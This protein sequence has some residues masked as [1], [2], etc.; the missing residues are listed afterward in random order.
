MKNSCWCGQSHRYFMIKSYSGCFFVL[1]KF[2]TVTQTT[3]H[4][5]VTTIYNQYLI[6]NYLPMKLKMPMKRAHIYYIKNLQIKGGGAQRSE[7]KLG[8]AN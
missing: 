3:K 2:I 6:R 7:S 4:A 8:N 5:C 1:I